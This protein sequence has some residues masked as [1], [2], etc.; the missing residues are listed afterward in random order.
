MSRFTPGVR[1][2]S[3]VGAEPDARD[4][5]ALFDLDI[6]RLADALRPR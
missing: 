2:A 1:L 5:I 3:S 6:A 4:Y